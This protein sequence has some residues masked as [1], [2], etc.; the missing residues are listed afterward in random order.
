MQEDLGVLYFSD[1]L[2]YDKMTKSFLGY[3]HKIETVKERTL[4]P[5]RIKVEPYMKTKYWEATRKYYV[6]K[7]FSERP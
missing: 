7:L 3:K 4:R 2:K 1:Q 6:P 5:G